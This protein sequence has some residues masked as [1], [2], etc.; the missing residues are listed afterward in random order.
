MEVWCDTD[1][2]HMC[3]ARR[4]HAPRMCGPDTPGD[5]ARWGPHMSGAPHVWCATHKAKPVAHI[6]GCAADTYPWSTKTWCAVDNGLMDKGFPS[7]DGFRSRRI[8][9]DEDRQHRSNEGGMGR[10]H[11]ARESG[12]GG[13]ARLALV[14]PLLH[15]LRF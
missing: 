5:S 2:C 11:A 15:L 4:Y 14:A 9:Q 7:S 10:P 6:L 3:G 13:H 12:H 1:T 8:Q